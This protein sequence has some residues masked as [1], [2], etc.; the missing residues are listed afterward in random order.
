VAVAVLEEKS[1]D[2]HPAYGLQQ[3]K[4]YLACKRLH[5]PFVV[6]A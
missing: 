6:L 1:E 3:S 5:V 2:K 4:G